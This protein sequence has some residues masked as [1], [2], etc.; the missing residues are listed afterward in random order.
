M[1][2][3]ERLRRL[4]LVLSIATFVLISVGGLVRASGAG[5]G[6]P[7]WPLCFG[8]LLPPTSVE[9]VP[10]DP[11][12]PEWK[13]QFNVVLAWTEYLNR[14]YG[15]ICGIIAI[16]CTVAVLRSPAASRELK[17]TMG[18]AMFLFVAQGGLGGRVV[19]QHL[20]SFL[21]TA[22]FLA[23]LV[24]ACVLLRLNVLTFSRAAVTRAADRVRTRV[25]GL[26][27]IRL[28][29]LLTLSQVFLGT[30]VR[31]AIDDV[32]DTKPDGASS[33]LERAEWLAQIP[34]VDIP[35]RQLGMLTFAV[36]L[37][38]L[39]WVWQKFVGS[40]RGLARICI[41]TGVAAIGQVLA[42]LALA[43]IDFP[44]WAMVVHLSIASW[45]VGGLFLCGELLKRPPASV[46]D[47]G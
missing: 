27:L 17:R 28:S 39:F 42:G 29:M 14:L 12:H 21:V 5:L 43:Y 36:V 18:L 34:E 4:L 45:M 22:H 38:C 20:D 15:I 13:E 33:G 46:G 3:M 26:W 24:I 30:R 2:V 10:D 8:Q 37:V 31:A 25:V 40:D 32:K 9:G 6:C 47:A 35:H 41:W 16:W 19:Q 11:D 7:D 1:R 23:A 44:A